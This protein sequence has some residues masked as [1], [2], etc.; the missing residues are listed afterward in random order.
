[1][2]QVRKNWLADHGATITG[3]TVAIANAWMTIDWS[4]FDLKKEYPKLVLS[5]IIAVGG[6]IST[7]KIKQS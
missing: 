4:T 2:T 5:A 3:L 7:I 1:M 6:Y